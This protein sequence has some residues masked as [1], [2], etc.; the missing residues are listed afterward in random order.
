MRRSHEEYALHIT[1]RTICPR[2]AQSRVGILVS[3]Q[4]EAV[5]VEGKPASR[6]SI[7]LH[8]YLF[9]IR[10]SFIP[11]EV[12]SQLTATSWSPQLRR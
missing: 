3:V 10:D 1:Q 11:R 9:C 4:I 8:R 12:A 2:D 7:W 5:K 6:V